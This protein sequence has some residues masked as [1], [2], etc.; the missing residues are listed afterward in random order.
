[1]KI[2]ICGLP[3][4]G[5]TWLAKRLS[6]NIDNCAW[7]NADVV[8]TASNDWD[9]SKEGRARQAMRMQTFANFEK[10]NGRFVICD[11]V[12]PTKISRDSFGADYLIWLN[13]I[14]EGRVVANKK[15]ELKNAKELP[16]E[17]ETLENTQA[18]KDTTN[19]F[20]NPKNANTVIT[21]F[22]TDEEIEALANKIKNV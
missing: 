22:M 5:K 13:T 6:Q 20:E 18:F 11:F 2:L 3:G 15:N 4:S 16:F 1:M 21:N 7:Y 9:F 12:A 10:N 8:R 17:I 19:I 14:N